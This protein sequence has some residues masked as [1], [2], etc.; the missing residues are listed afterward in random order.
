MSNKVSDSTKSTQFGLAYWM[1]RVLVEVDKAHRDLDPDRIHD[2]RVA[3]RRCKSMAEEFMAIDSD[4]GWRNLIK[5][6]R[7]LFKRLGKLRDTQILEDWIGRLGSPED[8]V[9]ITML[10]HLAQGERKL[11]KTAMESLRAFNRDRWSDL[12]SR[13]QARAQHLPPGGAVFQLGAMQAWNEAHALHKQA[14]RNRSDAAYH[15]LRIGIKKFRYT[16]ENFLPLLH[17]EWGRDLKEMQ[18]CLGEAH[19]LFIFW[20]T[21]M[22][23]KVFPDLESRERWRALIANEKSKRIDRYRAKMAGNG[24]LWNV[25]RRGLPSQDQLPSATLKMIEKWAQFQGINITRARHVRSLAMQ[26]FEGLHAGNRAEIKKQRPV[27]SLAAILQEFGRAKSGKFLVASSPDFGLGLPSTLGFT[28]ESLLIAA[29]VIHGQRAG[30]HD[31]DWEMYPELSGE[32]RKLV[33]ELC[34]I[35]RLAR[36]LSRD[37]T[38]TIRSIRVEQSVDS[39][40]ILASGYSYLGPLAEKIARARYLLEFACRKPILIRSVP[41]L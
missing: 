36:V 22:Q 27:I 40:T 28:T 9:Y 16:V 29:I 30:I 31:L 11:K 13:L 1:E 25:W 37:K 18:D 17:E 24:S 23:F 38:Q 14:L 35:L 33:L 41:S 32:Q 26:M 2:L 20:Q 34:G 15:R 10:F 12:I 4:K 3:L 39:I 21:A 8:T 6:G 19:D 7:Q 5:E